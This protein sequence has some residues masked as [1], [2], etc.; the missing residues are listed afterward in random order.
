MVHIDSL[1]QKLHSFKNLSSSDHIDI[2]KIIFA[3]RAI[4]DFEMEER[5]KN[6]RE[7]GYWFNL[8]RLEQII[9]QRNET[10]LDLHRRSGI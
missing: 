9:E 7:K 6:N 1:I 8:D 3:A 10:I 4:E 2:P 5:I